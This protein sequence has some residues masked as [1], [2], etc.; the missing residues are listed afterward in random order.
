V[1]GLPGEEIRLTDTQLL[2]NGKPVVD[3]GH[4]LEPFRA[5]VS[6]H[7]AAGQAYVVPANSYYV[8]PDN[9]NDAVGSMEYGAADR[10]RIPHRVS[11]WP[12]VLKEQ[13]KASRLLR[14][15]LK[16]VN[17]RLPVTVAPGL[18]LRSVEVLDDRN[19]KSTYSI[20]RQNMDALRGPRAEEF[21]QAIRDT[22]CQSPVFK[23]ATGLMVRYHFNPEGPGEPLTI[24]SGACAPGR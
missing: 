14:G 16:P 7:P 15:F 19:V 11:A 12:D 8:I 1:V 6:K 4:P 2:V 9:W 23:V 20:D 5:R 17:E 21:L 22:F 10:S 18:Q 13:G 3:R 24:D